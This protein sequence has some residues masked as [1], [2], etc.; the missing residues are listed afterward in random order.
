MISES[1]FTAIKIDGICK[2]S[3]LTSPLFEIMTKNKGF[4]IKIVNNTAPNYQEC[5]DICKPTWKHEVLQYNFDAQDFNGH[6]TNKI[7]AMLD[8]VKN[9]WGAHLIYLDTDVFQVKPIKEE[10]FTHDI[11]T[12]R[13]VIRPDRPYYKEVNAGVFFM[14][15]NSK[16]QKF[17]EEWLELDKEYQKDKSIPYPEQRAFND[18][19]YKYYDSDDELTVGNV[20]E[21]LY[22]LEADDTKDWM[23]RIEKYKP[24]LIHLKNKRWQKEFSMNWLYGIIK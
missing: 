4:D 19:C 24:Y 22:N 5:L 2:D 12:T 13:M 17:C 14:R 10:I 16:T 3:Y 23:E 18:L 7:R 15:A 6:C 21:N 9:N 1:R 11:I 8:A 20:S